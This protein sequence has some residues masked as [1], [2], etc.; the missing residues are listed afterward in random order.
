MNN[1]A[2]QLKIGLVKVTSITFSKIM[3]D[4]QKI[5]DQFWAKDMRSDERN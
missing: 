4:V 3:A 5:E 1:L 2:K